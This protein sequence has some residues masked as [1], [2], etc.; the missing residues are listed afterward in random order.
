M[1]P[2]VGRLRTNLILT[3]LP[4]DVSMH[5]KHTLFGIHIWFVVG[6]YIA[7]TMVL[8][9]TVIILVDQSVCASTGV[10]GISLNTMCSSLRLVGSRDFSVLVSL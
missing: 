10:D 8:H 7:R 9:V 6:I 3:T 1:P 2:N 4:N 5:S